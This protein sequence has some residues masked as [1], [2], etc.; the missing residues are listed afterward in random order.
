MRRA[1]P[2]ARTHARTH[3]RGPSGRSL[4]RPRRNRDGPGVGRGE[5]G[6]WLARGSGGAAAAAAGVSSTMG[7]G[8]RR[9]RRLGSGRS[10][11]T[12]PTTPTTR[13]RSHGGGRHARSSRGGRPRCDVRAPPT[14][15]VCLSDVG[16]GWAGRRRR[17]HARLAPT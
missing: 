2:H 4:A 7:G 5:R 9:R 11:P 8:R 12:T 15:L 10:R 14:T 13:R 6:S 17:T 3:A 16:L 1:A